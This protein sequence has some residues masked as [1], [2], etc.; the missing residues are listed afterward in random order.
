MS[1]AGVAGSPP[2]IKGCKHDQ[3]PQKDIWVGYGVPF[4]KVKVGETVIPEEESKI[5]IHLVVCHLAIWQWALESP[6]TIPLFGG[7]SH[8][9]KL[10]VFQCVPAIFDYQMANP[11]ISYD[12]PNIIP[13]LSPLDNIKPYS[14]SISQLFFAV[15]SQHLSCLV[16][17]G[18]SVIPTSHV[19]LWLGKSSISIQWPWLRNRL[20]LP[21]TFLAYFWGLDWGST[22]IFFGPKIWYVLT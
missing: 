1:F 8:L 15:L 22:A 16:Q 19:G 9:Y 6:S 14:S 10:V 2:Q 7:L 18:T 17:Q 5:I 12:Y 3:A 13:R 4:V 21:G 11:R 20:D